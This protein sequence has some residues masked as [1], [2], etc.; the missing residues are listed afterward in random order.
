MFIL[1]IIAAHFHKVGRAF[2]VYGNMIATG[3]EADNQEMRKEGYRGLRLLLIPRLL[4]WGVVGFLSGVRNAEL[5]G[6]YIWVLIIFYIVAFAIAASIKA[7][8]PP[9]QEVVT[10]LSDTAALKRAKVGLNNLLDIILVVLQSLEQQLTD[11]YTIQ[12]PKSKGRLAYTNIK[13]CIRVENGVA[14]TTVAFPYKGEVNKEK[15]MEDFNDCLFSLLTSGELPGRPL[16]VFTGTDNVPRAGIQAIHCD[17]VGDLI[18]LEV[19]QP[20]EEA[21]P[22]L[23]ALENADVTEPNEQGVLYDDGP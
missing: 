15:V 13:N 10:P 4:L 11:E 9:K 21:I 5:L 23:N 14:S 12:C 16:A 1:R 8:E 3:I 6:G 7:P 19:I 22:L 18:I 17:I 20:T 2:N